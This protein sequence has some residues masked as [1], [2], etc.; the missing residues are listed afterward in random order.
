[1]K[2]W[3]PSAAA[4]TMSRGKGLLK[5]CRDAGGA[6]QHAGTLFRAPPLCPALL[7]L[8]PAPGSLFFSDAGSLCPQPV[9]LRSCPSPRAC[10][11]LLGAVCVLSQ[12]TYSS[13]RARAEP[14]QTPRVGEALQ[15]WYSLGPGVTVVSVVGR[16]QRWAP[17]AT[18]FPF[19]VMAGATK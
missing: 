10:L 3:S 15:T 6:R 11:S 19:L 17:G 8:L 2:C 4:E 13:S 12:K 7:S 1:M 14:G 5:S 16:P 9:V 18:H